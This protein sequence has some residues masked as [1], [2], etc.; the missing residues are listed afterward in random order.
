MLTPCPRQ[1]P[2][3]MASPWHVA[4]TWALAFSLQACG[5]SGTAA[6]PQPRASTTAPGASVST[7]SGPA[8][9]VGGRS[10]PSTG[11]A[12]Q[13][14]VDLTTTL[15]E[16]AGLLSIGFFE[17]AIE[18][19]ARQCMGSYVGNGRFVTAAHCFRGI[20]GL[21]SCPPA[22][23]IRWLKSEADRAHVLSGDSTA[24]ESIQRTETE[25]DD[26]LDIAIVKLARRGSW[27]AQALTFL[28]SAQVMGMS[29]DIKNSPVS[30]KKNPHPPRSHWC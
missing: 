22:M 12:P 10:K 28:P 29:S 19:N 16:K 6:T 11:A 9:D 8:T 5:A 20:A 21:P 2:H 13:P 26:G 24:C 17:L 30:A 14:F 27:P 18:E 15:V 4:M 25:G 7:E 23:R 1:R 3:R